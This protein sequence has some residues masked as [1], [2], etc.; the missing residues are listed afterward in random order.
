MQNNVFFL[1]VIIITLVL[2]SFNILDF[3]KGRLKA[4]SLKKEFSKVEAV[5]LIIIFIATFLISKTRY[6]MD[7]I[8]ISVVLYL[9]PFIGINLKIYVSEKAKELLYSGVVFSIVIVLCMVLL[10]ADIL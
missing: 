3:R 7:A 5:L 4:G 8:F 1:V 2:S 10:I 6:Q 9:L